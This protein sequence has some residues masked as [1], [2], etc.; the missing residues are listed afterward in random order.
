[1]I[2][3]NEYVF[4]AVRQYTKNDR[5]LLIA[6]LCTRF[7]RE[8]LDDLGLNLN[9]GTA[10]LISRTGSELLAFLHEY[11][12]RTWP[13][14]DIDDATS[15]LISLFDTIKLVEKAG[16]QLTRLVQVDSLNPLMR[17]FL[18]YQVNDSTQADVTSSCSDR[19]LRPSS[20]QHIPQ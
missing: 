14:E 8:P 20:S 12:A 15:K 6:L 5:F 13:D 4:G 10:W 11:V 7:F 1:M 2:V 16:Q 17:E 19:S 3:T 9:E 18:T